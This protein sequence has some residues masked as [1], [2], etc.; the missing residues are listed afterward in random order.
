ML[1]IINEQGLSFAPNISTEKKSELLQQEIVNIEDLLED[2]TDLKWI[3][4][5][6]IEGSLALSQVEGRPPSAH[7]FERVEGWLAILRKLDLQR[8]GRW[9]DFEKSLELFRHKP[10]SF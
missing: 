2:Y 5:S 10:G 4:E 6:L 3:Y 9:A 7:E 1:S 8:Q